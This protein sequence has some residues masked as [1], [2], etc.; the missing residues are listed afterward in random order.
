MLIL[1][2]ILSLAATAGAAQDQ[3]PSGEEARFETCAMLVASDPEKAVDQANAW[4]IAGGGVPARQCL[5]M[6]YAQQGRWTPAAVAFEQAAR[7]SEMAQDGR[8]ARLWVQAGNARLAAGEAQAARSAF[9]TALASGTLEGPLKGEAHLDRAR[10]CVALGDLAAARTDL[11]AALALVPE[12]PLAWLLSA[13]LA[14]RTNDL[15][16][17][18]KDIAEATKRSPDDASVALE[19]GNIAIRVGSPDAARVAWQGAIAN[20]PGSDAAKAAADALKQLD[21]NAEAPAGAD[22]PPR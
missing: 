1:P 9:G 6:A 16:R 20:Q 22:T 21:E 10:A 3:A 7:D 13:T 4:R 5:A 17:A 2:F 14:R 19:A 18:Q 11:D 8:A 12:D 15:E